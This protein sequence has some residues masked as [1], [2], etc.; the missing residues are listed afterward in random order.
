MMSIFRKNISGDYKLSINDDKK[1]TSNKTDSFKK[2]PKNIKMLI[3]I[4]LI[5]A[6]IKN[7]IYKSARTLS[8]KINT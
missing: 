8:I 7:I 2:Q 5:E 3:A 4:Q 1:Q 6:D